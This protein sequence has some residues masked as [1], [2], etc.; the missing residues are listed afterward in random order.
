MLERK[1]IPRD[2]IPEV[3]TAKW[4]ADVLDEGFVPV[5]KRLI[6]CISTLFVGQ[7]ALAH[8]AVILAIADYRRPSLSRPPSPEYLAFTAGMDTAIF[9]KHLEELKGRG[10]VS[11]EAD[12]NA[13][14]VEIE[15]LLQE[16]VRLTPDEG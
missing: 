1:K 14:D 10:L 2:K 16:I 13:L 9:V 8:L 11:F 15:A 6:R 3:V 4:S 7:D 5:P 12:E